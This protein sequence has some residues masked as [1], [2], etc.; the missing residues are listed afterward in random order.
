MVEEQWFTPQDR[1]RREYLF[2][3]TQNTIR[4][5][6]KKTNLVFSEISSL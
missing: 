3:H 1:L 5:K 2:N 4:T 6:K